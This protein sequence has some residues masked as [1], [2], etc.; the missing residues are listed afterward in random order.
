[1]GGMR[2]TLF[3]GREKKELFCQKYPRLRPLIL[4]TDSSGEN[5]CIED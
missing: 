2:G 1:M 5:N 4:L 3:W